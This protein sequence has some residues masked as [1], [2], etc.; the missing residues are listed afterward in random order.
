[1]R[2]RRRNKRRT[3]TYFKITLKRERLEDEA[4]FTTNYN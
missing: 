3:K 4:F 2:I 1:M